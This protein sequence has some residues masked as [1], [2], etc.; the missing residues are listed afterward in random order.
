MTIGSIC[1]QRDFEYFADV[2]IA[3]GEC[4]PAL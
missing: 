3:F 1:A 2:G 4:G